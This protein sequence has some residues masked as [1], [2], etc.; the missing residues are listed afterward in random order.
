MKNW[1]DDRAWQGRTLILAS[2]LIAPFLRFLLQNNYLV[3]RPEVVLPLMALLLLSLLGASLCRP[4]LTFRLVTL[5]SIVLLSADATRKLLYPVVGW[6]SLPQIFLVL[7][8][9][10][11]PVMH[12]MKQ[13]FYRIALVFVWSSLGVDVVTIV[14]F[15]VK[16]QAP[17]AAKPVQGHVLYLILDGHIGPEGLPV[18]VPECGLA[19][20]AVEAT[21]AKH[22]FDLY[23]YAYSNFLH[24]V[25]SIPSILNFRIEEKHQVLV[26][27]GSRPGFVLKRNAVL[28][29][30]RARGYRIQL[31]Q[32]DFLD[33][34]EA[35]PVDASVTYKVMGLAS[36]GEL[37]WPWTDR[38]RRVVVSFARSDSALGRL[39]DSV[40]SRWVRP[41]DQLTLSPIQL[42]QVWPQAFARDILAAEQKTLFF[43]HLLT[44]HD[45]YSHAKDGKVKPP[46]DWLYSWA[47]KAGF[48]QQYQAYAEQIQAVGLQLDWLFET[49][50][51]EGVYE[52]MQ[53]IVHG[54]H[55]ARNTWPIFRR[56][57]GARGTWGA[58]AGGDSG[59]GADLSRSR[60]LVDLYSTLLAIKQPGATTPRRIE[61]KGSVVRFLAETLAPE[62]A[63][64]L[65]RD[66]D[67]VYW[68]DRKDRR[69]A[70]PPPDF[71]GSHVPTR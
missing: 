2:I 20:Q 26:E 3:L 64:G 8:L 68:F 36:L 27:K 67:Q 61:R 33:F 66:S 48:E 39:L 52:S 19:K 40:F 18:E 38:L 51:K 37:D 50:H 15:S 11:A 14:P 10:L 35:V 6:L 17:R 7:L 31:Y 4:G 65:A 43:A 1:L 71:S 44:P 24:S 13:S 21:F 59:P 55:G 47:S 45:P 42:A 5:L 23:P 54:D 69:Q 30:Y 46:K 16:A 63:Q 60:V 56:R 22:D 53:I 28:E 49:L 57:Y 41:V 25:D 12:L 34:R 29:H 70:F 9:A 62:R 58:G 32:S